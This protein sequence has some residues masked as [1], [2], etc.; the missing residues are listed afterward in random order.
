KIRQVGFQHQTRLSRFY[1]AADVLA[2]PSLRFETWG[3]VVNEALHHGVPAVVSDAVGCAPDLI[4][5]GE[6]GETFSE[7]SLQELTAALLRCLRFVGSESVRFRCRA[8]VQNY[9]I[10]KAAAGIAAAYYAAISSN[11]C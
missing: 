9:S 10:A 7:G 11:G 6:T 3:L 2:L 4:E 1:H 8:K 5:P